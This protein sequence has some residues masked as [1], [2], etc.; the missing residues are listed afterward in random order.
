VA[1]ILGI[2]HLEARAWPWLT[3]QVRIFSDRLAAFTFWGWQAVIEAVAITLPLGYTQGKEY[4]APRS[5]RPW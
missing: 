5:P 2:E 1:E 4:A 3:C